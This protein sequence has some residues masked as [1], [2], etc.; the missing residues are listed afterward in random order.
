MKNNNLE[1]KTIILWSILGF[2]IYTILNVSRGL[3]DNIFITIGYLL[4]IKPL[5]LRFYPILVNTIFVSFMLLL[6]YSYVGKIDSIRTVD[7]K[8]D[9]PIRLAKKIGLIALSIFLF[10][11]I[12]GFLR[13]IIL[14]K[15]YV[16]SFSG[17]DSLKKIYEFKGYADILGELV[18]LI[19]ILVIFFRLI[20][21][22]KQE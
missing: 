2:F 21:N 9:F 11:W 4:K 22:I 1:I 14:I 15:R 5:I 8:I 13:E 10:S 12:L 7:L 20:N 18:V 16:Y 19:I 17:S 3:L 6:F